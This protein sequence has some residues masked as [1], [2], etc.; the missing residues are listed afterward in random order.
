MNSLLTYVLA[1]A[2]LSIIMIFLDRKYNLLRDTSTAAVKPFSL[3]RVQ[4]AWWTVIIMAGFITII[5]TYQG[6]IPTFNNSTLILLGISAGTTTTASMIDLSDMSQPNVVRNQNSN[7]VNLF[8]DILSD[9]KGVNIHRL[10]TVL[11]HLI[12][13]IWFIAAILNH[14]L[15]CPCPVA[16]GDCCPD[17]YNK[18][19]PVL[20]NNNLILLGLSSGVYATLKAT[21]NKA[22]PAASAATADNLALSVDA[23]T[24]EMPVG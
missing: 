3:G 5:L 10:Q 12:F 16:G 14:L 21:E 19:F 24:E 2:V 23:T 15:H 9:E 13:G 17:V 6:N 22:K 8:L 7:G 4:L 1:F 20:E 11:F 18:I